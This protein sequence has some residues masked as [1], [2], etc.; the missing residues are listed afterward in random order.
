MGWFG[1]KRDSSNNAAEP[2]SAYEQHNGRDFSPQAS[3]RSNYVAPEPMPAE[4]ESTESSHD[5]TEEEMVMI[6][7]EDDDTFGGV[8]ENTSSFTRNTADDAD[9]ATYADGSTGNHVHSLFNGHLMIWKFEAE[10]GTCFL[11]VP[12]CTRRFEA[13]FC[14][15]HM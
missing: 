12:A 13:I 4:V 11:R 2:L 6:S 8:D 10:E 9:H 1:K 14:D 7:K 5:F 3:P 15:T